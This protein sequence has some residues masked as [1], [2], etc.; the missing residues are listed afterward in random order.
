MLQNFYTKCDNLK[1]RVILLVNSTNDILIEF[2]GRSFP[3]HAADWSYSNEAARDKRFVIMRWFRKV[4][5][6]SRIY[7][8]RIKQMYFL[9]NPANSS[10][11]EL[12]DRNW[13]K[14][15][16]SVYLSKP[17]IIHPKYWI[18]LYRGVCE[19]GENVSWYKYWESSSN[20]DIY[21]RL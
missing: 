9:L 17:W 20:D 21:Y 3:M 2:L 8:S 4:F 19:E 12:C 15:T 14:S 10:R 5:I 1:F 6:N 18:I 16:F 7:F 11:L 13:M